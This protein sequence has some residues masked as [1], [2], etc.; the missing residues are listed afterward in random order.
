MYKYRNDTRTLGGIGPNLQTFA[1][2]L[3]HPD[4]EASCLLY[5]QAIRLGICITGPA[6]MLLS[7]KTLR[8]GD[9]AML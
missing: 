7:P 6:N 1:D 8:E 9:V 5:Q 4:T 3:L 2:L